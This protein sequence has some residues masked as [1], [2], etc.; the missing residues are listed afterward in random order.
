MDRK[1]FRIPGESRFVNRFASR[2]IWIRYLGTNVYECVFEIQRRTFMNIALRKRS[3]G[4]EV[5]VN[6]TWQGYR[7][8]SDLI[9]KSKCTNGKGIFEDYRKSCDFYTDD[10]SVHVHFTYPWDHS[11]TLAEAKRE[12]IRRRD[13]VK[14]EFG[15]KEFIEF[16]I[17]D[18]VT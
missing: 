10:L 1:P 4:I 14:K 7:N 12:L 8:A 18:N 6:G 9:T 2:K 13:L 17:E 5:R 3:G 15:I 11:M 16:D